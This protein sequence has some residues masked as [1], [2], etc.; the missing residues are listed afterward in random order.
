M[1]P[2]D[3]ARVI[4]FLQDPSSHAPIPDNV[5]RLETHGAIV[6]LAGDTAYKIKK[7]VRFSYMDFSTLEL[8]RRACQRELEINQP[9]APELYL[10]LTAITL[11]VDGKLAMSGPGV[12]VEWC[13]R[14]RRF[15]QCDLLSARAGSGPLDAG[16]CQGLAQAIADYH[17]DAPKLDLADNADRLAHTTDDVCRQ[18]RTHAGRLGSRNVEEFS[19]LLRQN[20]ASA[21]DMLTERG[22]SGFVRRVHGD[23]HL[24]NIVVWKGRPVL[25]DAIEFDEDIAT[26]DTLY[27]LAFLL[28]DLE[29]RG[30]R[31][32]ANR[33]LNR[34]LW[35]GG[36]TSNLQA[37]AAMP[38][39]LGLRAG[40]RAMVLADRA[41]Q[42]NGTPRTACIEQARGY[43]ARATASLAPPRPTLIAVGG[44][45]GTGKSTL[46]ARL[47]P[48]LGAAPGALHLRSDLERKSLHGVTETD[49]L[50][51]TAYSRQASMRVYEVL[52]EKAGVALDAGHAAIVDAVFAQPQERDA[53]EQVAS[54]R[55]IPFSGLWLEAPPEVL[56]GRVD[57][58]RGDASDADAAVVEKQLTYELGSIN[59][60]RLASNSPLD[61][62]VDR[63]KL[64][65]PGIQASRS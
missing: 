43:L 60:T 27:D 26:I 15:P 5:Q 33:I 14:M 32:A 44:L 28:M 47:A 39:F 64:E 41:L 24:G 40:V 6:F 38:L 34:Y 50:P 19:G 57:Q 11:A 9:H 1:S 42:G 35:H 36:G 3:Q 31:L 10:G 7:A 22:K 46:A 18:L 58:R 52:L 29:H 54:A 63:A 51:A 48:L 23:L 45:S 2:F 25:F 13:V 8:R 12:P 20:L 30:Q 62:L 61:D 65:L 55:K 56:R 59:W 16:L 21:R 49:R 17:R 4:Q 37:L 53:I